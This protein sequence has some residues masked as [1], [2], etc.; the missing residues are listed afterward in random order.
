MSK[1]TLSV[2]EEDQLNVEDNDCK[3]GIDTTFTQGFPKIKQLQ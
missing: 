2:R 3:S 1:Q